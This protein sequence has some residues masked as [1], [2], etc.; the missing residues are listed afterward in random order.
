MTKAQ[1]LYLLAI[2]SLLEKNVVAKVSDIAKELKI[3]PPSVSDML[4][5]LQKNDLVI[6]QSYK[7]AKLT[8]KGKEKLKKIKLRTYLFVEF[9]KQLDI[10]EKFAYNDAK[11]LESYLSP[12]TL[13][14]MQKFLYFLKLFSNSPC[15]FKYFKEFSKTGKISKK[16]LTCSI[17]NSIT[18][19]KNKKGNN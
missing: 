11:S 9:F 15:F 16:F 14:Q 4:Y 8:K 19:S 12:F 5:K 10:P 6:Y 3:K 18:I 7:G 13:K 1:D 2:D 17:N